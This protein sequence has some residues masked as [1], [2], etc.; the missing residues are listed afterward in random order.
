MV[1]E[2]NMEEEI[3]M[4]GVNMVGLRDRSEWPKGEWDSEPQDKISWIDP[5]TNLECLMVRNFRG[6]WCGYVGVPSGHIAYG[7][8]HDTLTC[9]VHGGLTFSGTSGGDIC[10]PNQPGKPVDIWWLGFDCA[11]TTDNWPGLGHNPLNFISDLHSVLSG[12]EQHLHHTYG[13]KNIKYVKNEIASLAKQLMES[14]Y[15]DK[16]SEG[17]INVIY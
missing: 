14:T 9:S 10:H 1:G 15:M 12:N 7:V 6:A 17:E 3:N 11:H 13:Y 4:V 8:D 5:E 2:I 16:L